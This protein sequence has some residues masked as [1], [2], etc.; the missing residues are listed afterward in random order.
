MHA[1]LF[2]EGNVGG[3][4]GISP[5][6]GLVA[7]HAHIPGGLGVAGARIGRHPQVVGR[8]HVGEHVVPDDRGVFI[9]TGNPVQVPY[10]VAVVVAQ[11]MPQSC[12]LDEHLQPAVL[13]QRLVAGDDAIALESHGDIGV[14]VPSSGAG[15]PVGRAFLAANRTPGIAG[16]L[17]V[18]LRCA[19]L[20]QIQS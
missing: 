1:E 7:G 18:Q 2:V 12:R 13:L 8:H 3:I 16:A 5:R 9:G 11:R 4:S 6:S 14:D 10:T 20:G 17:Q 15:G 19:L